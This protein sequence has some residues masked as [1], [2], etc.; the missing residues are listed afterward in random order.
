MLQRVEAV[1]DRHALEETEMVKRQRNWM[2]SLVVTLILV[3]APMALADSI[4][5]SVPFSG[6]GGDYYYRGF[7]LSD[8]PGTNLGT[9]TLSYMS[10]TAGTYSASL[11]ARVGAYDGPTIGE[12]K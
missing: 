4:I 10:F 3:S 1:L 2:P 5:F 6:T 12:H 9:V 7:Y 11:T 8:Y